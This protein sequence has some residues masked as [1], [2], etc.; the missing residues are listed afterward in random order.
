MK[1]SKTTLY[2][3]KIEVKCRFCTDYVT[4]CP[5][6]GV[7]FDPEYSEQSATTYFLRKE[8]NLFNRIEM[9]EKWAI[10][11]DTY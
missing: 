3:S 2:N 5:A 11:G 7:R 1:R 6:F 9:N 10:F 8:I 4:V